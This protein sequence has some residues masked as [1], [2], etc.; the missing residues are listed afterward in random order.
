M[1]TGSRKNLNSYG[2]STGSRKKIV[3]MFPFLGKGDTSR[4]FVS[5]EFSRESSGKGAFL[6]KQV[7]TNSKELWD[8]YILLVYPR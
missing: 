4:A 2:L 7:I 8:V 5:G 1:I 3:C 6:V